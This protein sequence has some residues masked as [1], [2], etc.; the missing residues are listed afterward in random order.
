MADFQL[1]QE[2]WNQ[3]SNQINERVKTNKLLKKAVQGTYRKLTNVQ[4]QNS[5]NLP[6]TK[7]T[8]MKSGKVVK[9]VDNKNKNNKDNNKSHRMKSEISNKKKNT[10][11][12]NDSITKIQVS[13]LETSMEMEDNDSIGWR[14][15]PEIQLQKKVIPLTQMRQND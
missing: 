7:K 14:S 13:D 2:V 4:K 1:S 3:L 6:N 10:T 12:K 9:F 11:S 5:R 15:V 8:P